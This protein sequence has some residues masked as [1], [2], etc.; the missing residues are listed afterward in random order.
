MSK[1]KLVDTKLIAL[2]RYMQSPGGICVSEMQER[3]EVS[4]ASVY[5]Y[6]Q[7]MQ[8]D[9]ELPITSEIRGKKTYYFFDCEN[10]NIN[11]NIIESMSLLPSD[12]NFDM[13]DRVLLEF[14]FSDAEK[15]PS[16]KEDVQRLH[17]KMSILLA[18]AG[19]ITHSS[20][21]SD[22]GFVAESRLPYKR[23]LSFEEL[24]KK[25]DKA[26][27]NMVYTLCGASRE[28]KVC[29]VTYKSTFPEKTK[30]YRIMPLEV[31]SY[32][33]GF[34]LIAE[35]EKYD[36]ISKYAVERFLKVEVTEEHFERK[37]T[38]DIEWM[39][40]DPFGLVQGDQFEADILV[41]Q[42][43]VNAVVTRQWP[44]NRVSFSPPDENGDVVMHVITSGKYELTKWLRYMGDE[45]E[46][47]KP[48]KEELLILP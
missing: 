2:I 16:I 15:I 44:E 19:H 36:Y 33:G 40:S 26:Q 29:N 46:L 43:A 27:M 24:P 25:T 20:N 47:I 6:L 5:R 12:F 8:F 38:T 42:K 31:F 14:M 30:S 3:L 48:L 39:L 13:K 22:K 34:Y 41:R 37:T 7:K 4:R 23:I 10:E 11:R 9:M 18:F 1:G 21:N 35:T 32:R 45:V 28:H 17:S